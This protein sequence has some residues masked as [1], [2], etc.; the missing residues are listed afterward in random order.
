MWRAHGTKFSPWF[1]AHERAGRFDLIDPRGT[2]YTADDAET[3]VR[4]RLGNSLAGQNRTTES[5]A[6]AMVVSKLTID[7]GHTN[8]AAVND[9]KAVRFGLTR[10][11]CVTPR[12]EVTQAWA[13]KF[14]E[15]GFDGI[16]YCSRFT[17]VESANAW[18]I[19]GDAGPADG[20]EPVETISGREACIQAG[21]TVLPERLPSKKN[22]R[23]IKP[24]A[25]TG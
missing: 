12:Y 18:A 9:A 11:L 6:D 14:D 5:D 20:P 7:G 17:T 22:L 16:R 24:P 25:V 15:D 10:E 4:E 19:F 8:M 23:V 21:I 2:L 13:A 1:F 3:A